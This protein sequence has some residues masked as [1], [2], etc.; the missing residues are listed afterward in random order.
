[1]PNVE[2]VLPVEGSRALPQLVPDDRTCRSRSSSTRPSTRTA[3]P[4]FR[5]AVSLAIDRK[6]VS[7]LGEYGYA[8][9][10]T[11]TRD[12]AACTRSGSTRLSR[13]GRR[14]W[15]PTAPDAAKKTFTD[16][17]FTYKSGRSATTRRVTASSFQIHVIGGWSDWVASLQ[18]ITRNLQAVGIDAIG[19]A[20]ARL[21]RLAAERDEHE[22]RVAA[23]D[24][25]QQTTSRRG[26]TSTRTSIRH[27]TSARVSTRR[28]RATGSTT[29]APR[30]RRS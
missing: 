19:Q 22:V 3:S 7:K 27:R 10:T 16:A 2:S 9:P 11:R 4:A 6:T 13:R 25:R 30:E 21:G 24:L 1:M 26:R 8:P 12:R 15:P 28:R 17:G 18:I 5:K 20:R 23:L 29:R 14:R